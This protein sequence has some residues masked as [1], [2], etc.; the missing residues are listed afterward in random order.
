MLRSSNQVHGGSSFSLSGDTLVSV[1]GVTAGYVNGR[2]VVTDLSFTVERPG[3]VQ[4]TGAN[5]SGKSTVVELL[6]GYLRPW[7]GSVTVAGLRANDDAARATRRICRTKPALFAQ[8][9]SRDHLLLSARA[10]GADPRRQLERAGAFGLDP[11]LDDNAGV[12]SSGSAKK[13]W[14]LVCTAGDF[15]LAVLDEPYNALDSDSAALMSREIVDWRTHASVLLV[16]HTPPPAL[17]IDVVISL[18]ANGKGANGA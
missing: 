10:T 3:V 1:E 13:L 18:S 9:T 4:L 5:G 12:L 11:W 14:Y 6:S 16:C 8:M 15:A 2:A 7:Q 17:D